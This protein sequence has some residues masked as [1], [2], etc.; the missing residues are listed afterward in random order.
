MNDN[1]IRLQDF[2]PEPSPDGLA[3]LRA[4]W[5]SLAEP[6]KAAV[7]TLV[8]SVAG[9]PST[10]ELPL[11]LGIDDV[12]ELLGVSRSTLDRMD[13]EAKIPA[14]VKT[15]RSKKWERDGFLAWLR[16]RR[17]DGTTFSRAEWARLTI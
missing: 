6:V 11:M 15:G 12:I 8:R 16:A 14:P 1:T 2:R 7:L 17:P 9:V 4:H 5:P 13:A 3:E 10:G